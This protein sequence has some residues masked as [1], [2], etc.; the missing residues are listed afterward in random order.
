MQCSYNVLSIDKACGIVCKE[1]EQTGEIRCNILHIRQGKYHPCQ[2]NQENHINM[3]Q[4]LCFCQQF[5]QPQPFNRQEHEENQSPQYKVPA[6]TVPKSGKCP[7]HK[8]IPDGLC[9]AASA[10]AQRKYKYF[11]NQRPK[12]ICHLRQNSAIEPE[13]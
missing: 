8:G 6:C 1:R 9:K 7:D 4:Y 12:V 10:S 2:R 11:L 13:I 5:S 3:F